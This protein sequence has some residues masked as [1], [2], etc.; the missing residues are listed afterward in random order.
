MNLTNFA[1]L[2]AQGTYKNWVMLKEGHVAMYIYHQGA[3]LS[4]GFESG[5]HFDE[6]AVKDKAAEALFPQ[7][8]SWCNRQRPSVDPVVIDCLR[9]G[10]ACETQPG[11]HRTTL[12]Q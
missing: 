1:G 11:Q 2:E 5:E 8:D 10:L 6:M 9:Q 4:H 3:Q 12:D 7:V